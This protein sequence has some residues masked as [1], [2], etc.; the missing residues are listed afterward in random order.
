MAE[1]QVTQSTS[2][3]GQKPLIR[4][5]DEEYKNEAGNKDQPL[6]KK[7]KHVNIGRHNGTPISLRHPETA[8]NMY[9]LT[10][11]L[12]ELFIT[13]K[14]FGQI[15]KETNSYAFQKG[16]HS[17]KLNPNDFKSFIGVLLL[18]VSIPYPR[19]SIYCEM[20]EG[21]KNKLINSLIDK[22]NF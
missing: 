14:I 10:T 13:D 12:F 4:L 3:N 18:S 1:I 16:N 20:T 7:V 19:R 5:K 15:C 11:T 22:N 9:D 6:K 8:K 2:T 21:S 17:F